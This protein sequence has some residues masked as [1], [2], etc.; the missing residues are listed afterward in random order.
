VKPHRKLKRWLGIL[1]AVAVTGVIALNLLANRHAYAMMHF[2]TGGAKTEQ[3]EELTRFQKLKVLFQGVNLPRPQTTVPPTALGSKGEAVT[4]DENDGVKL[5]AWYCPGESSSPLVI[6]FHGYGGEKSATLHEARAFLKM[7]ASVLL[8]DFRG[9]GDSSES[10]TTIGFREADDVAAAVRFARS[11]YSPSRVILYGQSMGASAVLRAVRY[12]GVQA[13]DIIVE[14]VFDRM[15]STVQHRFEA[16]HVPSFPSAEL[17]VFWGGRQF[18]F[19]AFAHNPVEYAPGVR[20]PILFLHGAADP[21]ARID[22]ARRV[23]DAIPGA[24]TFREFPGARHEPL[25]VRFP[26]EWNE[27][28]GEFL[29]PNGVAQMR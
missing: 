6:L 20:C 26:K 22:E 28:V 3:A 11:H 27:V 19:D 8:V 29:R 7:G 1:A 25:V 4:I 13:D 21:R 18:G 5:G 2:S 15:L 23:Y 17:L 16:M 24:K 12:C 9:S 10:Y 14:A